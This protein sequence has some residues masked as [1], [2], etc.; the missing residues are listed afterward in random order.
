MSRPAITIRRMMIAVAVI[1]LMLG[2]SI[3]GWRLKT[4]RE[5]YIGLANSHTKIERIV[6]D[7][8]KRDE[9][10]A[11]SQDKLTKMIGEI[12]AERGRRPLPDGPEFDR[13]RIGQMEAQSAE[14]LRAASRAKIR[15]DYHA[16]LHRKY[17][18]AARRPW[19]WVEPDGPEPT[20]P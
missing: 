19:E 1:G 5:R 16:L 17:E 9:L 6:R 11:T 14:Y 12:A 3:Y 18:R 2:A 7:S 4:L 8:Q 10:L 15:A 13:V 20:W